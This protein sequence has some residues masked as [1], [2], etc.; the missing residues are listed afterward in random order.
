MRVRISDKARADLRHIYRSIEQKNPAAAD[1]LVLDLKSK[2]ARLTQFPFMGRER[3]E[4]AESLRSLLVWTCVVFYTVDAAEIAIVR[5]VDG[6]M[7]M[8]KELQ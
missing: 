2:I 3:S 1:R 5:I 6:R 8:E 4:F 7:D